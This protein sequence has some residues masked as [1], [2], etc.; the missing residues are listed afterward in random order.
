MSEQIKAHRVEGLNFTRA[1]DGQHA[2]IRF[3]AK[4]NFPDGGDTIWL[5]FTNTMLPYLASLAVQA[6]PQP[7]GGMTQDVPAAFS[8]DEVQFGVGPQ[9]ELVLTVTLEK[10]A[11]LS[12]RLDSG[13]AH[14]L[15]AGLQAALAPETLPQSPPMGKAN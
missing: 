7:V 4:P 8:P 5:A 12:Y 15:L 14:G 2:L 9:G 1:D 13:Q 3:R 10:G 11:A 6:L